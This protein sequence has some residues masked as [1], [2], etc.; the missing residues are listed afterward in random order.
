[1]AS[2]PRP[3][4]FVVLAVL[5][6]LAGLT[7]LAKSSN[8]APS[9]SSLSLSPGS[10]T[11]AL[12]CTGLSGSTGGEPGHFTFLNTTGSTRKL[13]VQV[14]SDKDD[15]SLTSLTLRPHRARSVTPQ[16]EV[17]GNSFAVAVQVNGG[18]VVGEEVANSSAEAPCVAAGVTNWY[19]SGFDTTVGSS[20]D[21]SI[22]N[23]TATPAVFN[24]STFS[25]SGYSA[26][27]PFQGLAVGAHDQMVIDL[28]SQIVNT[29]NIGVRVR[30]LRGSVVIDGVQD[31]GSVASFAQGQD[32]LTKTAWFP[33]VTTV[34]GALAQIRVANPSGVPVNVV[35]TV[36]VANYTVAP[37]DLTVAPYASGD[38]VITPNSAIPAAGYA[39]VK[40][41]ASAPVATAL[42]TGTSSGTALSSVVSPSNDFIVAD[43]AGRGYDA[44]DVTN[45]STSTLKVTFTSIP[46]PGEN[47]A[48]GQVQVAPGATDDILSVFSGLDTLKA[49]TLLITGSRSSLLV[50][51]T[52]PTTPSGVVVV[53]PLDGG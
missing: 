21:L 3:P 39:N 47:K 5:V 25:P 30:V 17:K 50:T 10:N 15:T 51:L 23:P 20:A 46:G 48:S 8:V 24:I 19:A 18:G 2:R 53:A 52:L 36:K 22:Y 35:A 1:M 42:V 4:L 13:N 38:I 14:V 34:N 44:A 33:A 16:S 45:T 26:P 27:A 12:Y 29:S 43:F 37:Q 31:S 6:V 9:A 7:T 11:T 28:G 41:K 40:V 32:A 49:K